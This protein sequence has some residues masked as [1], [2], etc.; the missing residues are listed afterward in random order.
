MAQHLSDDELVH[1]RRGG[2]DYR[3]VYAACKLATQQEGAPTV[4]LAHTVKGWALGRDF[5]ARN[6]THQIK[7]MSEAELKGFRDTLELPVGDRQLAEG[8]A[9]YYH[10]GPDS[11][12]VEYMRVRRRALGG[13]IPRRFIAAK[14]LTLPEDKP[15]AGFTASTA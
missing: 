3:K 5:E 13:P 14:P 7:K 15:N 12:E 11:E 6:A 2:H 1:L 4:I 10:P 8:H 9:P